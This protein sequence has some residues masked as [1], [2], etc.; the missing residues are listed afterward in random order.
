MKK[1]AHIAIIG[2]GIAGITAARHIRKRS[3]AAITVISGESEHFFSRTALMYIY[4]GH[5]QFAHTKPYEDS[6]WKKNN[7]QLLKKW[8]KGIDF[9][10][11]H[12]TFDDQSQ[13]RYDTLILATGSVPNFFG[14]PGQDLEGVQGLFSLQDLEKMEAAT[15]R[16]RRAI[17]VGGGLIGVEMA[18]M[19]LSRNISVT[20]LVREQAFWDNVLPREEAELVT[21]HILKHGVDLQLGTELKAI[22]GDEEGKARAVE[23]SKGETLAC[24]FVGLTVGV[25]PQTDFLKDSTLALNRGILVDEYLATNQPDVYAIG[26]CAE[27]KNPLPGR[28]AIE[29]VWY[30]GRMMGE[31]VARTVTGAKTAY[32]PGIW[33]NSAKFFDIE[34]QT[35]G[36][37]ANKLQPGESTFYWEH[38]QGKKCLRIVFDTQTQVCL[39]VNVFGIRLRHEVFDRWLRE[40]QPVQFVVENLATALFD[41]EFFRDPVAGIQAK[42]RQA[43]PGLA[44]P[45]PRPKRFFL[46]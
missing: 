37:V 2:N 23:T 1:Q 7:I 24:E 27:L 30:T 46:W 28:R 9:E 8:V 6:F 15:P 34:Y 10:K 14:W 17:I 33:F 32:N 43:Y 25:R 39:G 22:L 36:T 31:T 44:V 3:A 20:F 21:R 41:P 13:M 29:P 45:K 42:F 38:P 16:I 40:K 35:Y 19:L 4:M 18:E 26:D 12:L 5:M 11:K